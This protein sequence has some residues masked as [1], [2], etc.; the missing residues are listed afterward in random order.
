[1][2]PTLGQ[3]CAGRALFSRM[4]PAMEPAAWQHGGADRRAV[5]GC[6]TLTRGCVPF[7]ITIDTRNVQFT[8]Y[9]A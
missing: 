3:P 9:S 6:L 8:V 2:A 7:D 5:A 1:M 4:S